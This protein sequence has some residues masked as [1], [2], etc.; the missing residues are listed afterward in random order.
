MDASSRGARLSEAVIRVR[1]WVATNDWEDTYLEYG[2]YFFEYAGSVADMPLEDCLEELGELAEIQVE[3]ACVEDFL[4]EEYENEGTVVDAFLAA[5]GDDLDEEQRAYLLALKTSRM[6]LYE[7]VDVVPKS[8]LVVRDLLMKGD[9][10]TV[11][12]FQGSQT[13]LQWSTVATRIVEMDGEPQFS[14]LLFELSKQSRDDI[15]AGFEQATKDALKEVPKL[16]R[17]EPKT[18][19][20]MRLQVLRLIPSLVIDCWLRDQL[21]RQLPPTL[22]NQ[23]GHD[24][25]F[26]TLTYPIQGDFT[27][28]RESLSAAEGMETDGDTWTWLDENATVLASLKLEGEQLVV[29]VNSVERAEAVEALLRAALGETL[30]E[31]ARVERSLEEMLALRDEGVPQN[32]GTLEELEVFRAAA[33]E[34]LDNHYRATLDAPV[35]A[36]GNRTPR[37]LTGTPEGRAMLADWLKSYESIAGQPGVQAEI[38]DYDITWIW[39][40]LGISDLRQ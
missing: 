1:E 39:E 5:A 4:T 20:A 37:E 18:M 33:K 34:Y 16:L 7:V 11:R 19:R 9:P 6:S 31:P 10:V 32:A 23:S 35:P 12:E 2:D 22:Q 30:G 21:D 36:L 40:E 27:K 26:I 38:R 29:E 8:H 3:F 28:V 15:V 25:H 13:I 14:G 24:L 17:R